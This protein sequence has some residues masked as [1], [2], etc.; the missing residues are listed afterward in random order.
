MEEQLKKI[1]K[2]VKMNESLISMILGLMTVIIVGG[3][4]VNYWKSNQVSIKWLQPHNEDQVKMEEQ[5]ETESKTEENAAKAEATEKRV[6]EVK[7]GDNLWKI[8]EEV[9]GSGYNWVDIA[10]ANHLKNPGVLYQG[11]KLELPQVE[12]K[13]VTKQTQVQ[14]NQVKNAI[15]GDKYKVQKGDNLWQIAVRA[16]QD[17]YQWVKIAKAN[18]LANPNLIEV[19]QELIIPRK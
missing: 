14:E 18:K 16:Y 1:L 4:V 13:V 2:K 17:G 5:G 9:Y 3:L 10:K 19:G 8:A 12:K 11:Q 15:T 6:Y 7:R